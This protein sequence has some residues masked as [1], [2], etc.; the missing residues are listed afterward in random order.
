MQF[1]QI[2]F[3]DYNLYSFNQQRAF[4]AKYMTKNFLIN[5]KNQNHNENNI[6]YRSNALVKN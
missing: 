6:K 5:Q 1:M 2:Y 3:G 4:E